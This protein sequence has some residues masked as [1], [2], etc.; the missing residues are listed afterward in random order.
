[1]FI[2]SRLD[3]FIVLF[4]SLPMYFISKRFVLDISKLSNI[5]D[6]LHGLHWLLALNFLFILF[7]IQDL[8]LTF[9]FQIL[10]LLFV[11]FLFFRTQKK[12][13]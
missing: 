4:I 11:F 9:L 3:Y 10:F 6:F 8:I 13:S 7:S 1:M 2:L 5:T 12:N